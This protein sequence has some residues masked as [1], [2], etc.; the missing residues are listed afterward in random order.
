MWFICLCLQI[1]SCIIPS[2]KTAVHYA[3]ILDTEILTD[4][5]KSGSCQRLWTSCDDAVICSNTII[6]QQLNKG[7]I[8]CKTPLLN[9][10]HINFWRFKRIGIDVNGSRNVTIQIARSFIVAPTNIYNDNSLSIGEALRNIAVDN[11]VNQ[12]GWKQQIVV[13]IGFHFKGVVVNPLICIISGDIFDTFGDQ[14][15]CNSSCI[16][17]ISIIN[18]NVFILGQFFVFE[19]SVQNFFSAF[20][21]QIT[22][23]I[24]ITGQPVCGETFCSLDVAAAGSTVNLPTIIGIADTGIQND[25]VFILQSS[26]YVI[27]SCCFDSNF[28]RFRSG[29]FGLC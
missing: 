22:F 20:A 13:W 21:F 5:S 14:I 11:F 19:V 1:I 3:D 10:V 7:F 9:A 25:R 26:L 4:N 29:I 8:V 12:A 2:G 27:S 18:N 23:L 16:G 15:V 28:F 17:S 6:Q 24:V